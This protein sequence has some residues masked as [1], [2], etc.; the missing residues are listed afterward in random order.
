VAIC[1]RR[2]TRLIT[3]DR[4]TPP[5]AVVYL[6]RGVTMDNRQWSHRS[7]R[8]GGLVPRRGCRSRQAAAGMHEGGDD[9]FIT[10]I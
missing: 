1:S 5:P 2:R 7:A 9:G 8:A 3:I 6:G 10:E 4:R